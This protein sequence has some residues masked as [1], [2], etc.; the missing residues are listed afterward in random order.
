MV[1]TSGFE[2]LTFRLSVECSSQLSYAPSEKLLDPL[3]LDPRSLMQPVQRA[4]GNEFK[5]SDGKGDNWFTSNDLT[6]YEC[7]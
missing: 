1:G 7:I 2:P 5:S 6:D 4:L 3:D